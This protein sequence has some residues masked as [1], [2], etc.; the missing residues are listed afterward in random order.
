MKTEF[1]L[2]NADGSEKTQLT[3]FNQPGQPEFIPGQALAADLD[4]GPDGR[5]IAG[6]V[7]TQPAQNRGRIVLIELNISAQL[8]DDGEIA[9]R[10]ATGTNSVVR[11]VHAT[12]SDAELSQWE[13]VLAAMTAAGSLV[14]QTHDRRVSSR[15]RVVRFT[16]YAGGLPVFRGDV[17][18][19]FDGRRLVSV[20]GTFY[21]NCDPPAATIAPAD[22]V[23]LATRYALLAGSDPMTLFAVPNPN[24]ACGSAYVG[25]GISTTGPVVVFIDAQSGAFSHELQQGGLELSR[26]GQAPH[27]GSPLVTETIAGRTFARDLTRPPGIVTLDLGGRFERTLSALRAFQLADVASVAGSWN[28][29]AVRAFHREAAIAYDFVRTRFG[30]AGIS[31][32]VSIVGMVHATLG[33][34]MDETVI[35][36][37]FHAGAGR[38]FVPE[39]RDGI[40]V[41]TTRSVA[42]AFAQ[43]IVDYTAALAPSGDAG[44]I[45]AAFTDMVRSGASDSE[46]MLAD[47]SESATARALAVARTR[48]EQVDG[49]V[50]TYAIERVLFRT[51]VELLPPNATVAMARKATIQSARDL[52]GPASGVEAALVAGWS[53]AGVE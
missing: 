25:R 46:W 49:S 48:L 41:L 34:P 2:M 52:F 11:S 28:D 9:Q 16:Q 18:A 39:R 8:S 53:A 14:E 33:T 27:S 1:W 40:A 26:A 17:V 30:R 45:R 44:A 43:A 31:A 15:R 3:R 36:G 20:F 4:W 23:A 38:L 42:H 21:L 32:G 12:E 7:M 37:P 13:G 5:R 6:Y 19:Q 29:E 10:P 24:G 47:A 22:A 35:Q 51:V 50:R